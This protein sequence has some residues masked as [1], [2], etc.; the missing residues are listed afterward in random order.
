MA[1]VVDFKPESERVNLAELAGKVI[2]I[3][4]F[5]ILRSEKYKAD[6]AIIKYFEPPESKE[7]EA[8]TFSR[9]IIKQLQQIFPLIQQGKAVRVKVVD[10]GRY[11]M[12][13]PPR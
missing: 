13:A 1:E 4:D 2:V 5:K 6:L 12:L 3:T 11:L 7:K 10:A 8:Y 9:V